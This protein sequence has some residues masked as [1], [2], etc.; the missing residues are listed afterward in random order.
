M[1]EVYF[2]GSKEPF[3]PLNPWGRAMPKV[4]QR[5]R[6]QLYQVVIRY[7]GRE[8]PYGPKASRA[9]VEQLYEAVSAACRLGVVKDIRDPY[10]AAVK[11]KEENDSSRRMTLGSLLQMES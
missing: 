8:M 4:K 11:S 7:K 5:E 2:P 10:I 9:F 6:P 1:P 3:R